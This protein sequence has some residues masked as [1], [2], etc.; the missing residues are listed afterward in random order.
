L[1][2]EQCLDVGRHRH[3]GQHDGV[4]RRNVWRR[5]PA[6]GPA[7]S[8]RVRWVSGPGPG[9]AR[10]LGSEFSLR[11]LPQRVLDQLC[12]GEQAA[13]SGRSAPWGRRCPCGRMPAA[14]CTASPPTHRSRQQSLR[15]SCP[16]RPTHQPVAACA[17]CSPGDAASGQSCCFIGTFG[18]AAGQRNLK[19]VEL[20]WREHASGE[21]GGRLLHQVRAAV[22]TVGMSEGLCL[23]VGCVV[24]T[25]R[26][27]QQASA[28][29]TARHLP[30][31]SIAF[32]GKF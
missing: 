12:L 2:E 24:R 28:G 25:P 15:P 9:S 29:A 23:D 4:P 32:P 14:S 11:Y 18:P 3:L 19:P 7:E 30:G 21:H 6:T 20:I 31:K 10:R 13:S 8:R 22:S 26:Q 17:R 16:R 27:K 5:R 1:E